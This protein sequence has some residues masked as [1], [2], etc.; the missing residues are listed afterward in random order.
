[1]RPA[2]ARR[3]LSVGA[4]SSSERVGARCDLARE[5]AAVEDAF[6]DDRWLGRTRGSGIGRCVRDRPVATLWRGARAC[7]PP[8]AAPAPAEVARR[9][10]TSLETGFCVPTRREGTL[11]ADRSSG[12]TRREGTCF[13]PEASAGALRDGTFFER[14]LAE[15]PR[16]AGVCLEPAPSGPALGVS[17]L[18][19]LLRGGVRSPLPLPELVKELVPPSKTSSQPQKRK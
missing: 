3:R 8:L 13:E 5:G 17:G 16:G 4:P 15:P 10:V 19:A 6:P 1:M 9:P 11:L 12:S 18:R 14:S 7:E 2:E